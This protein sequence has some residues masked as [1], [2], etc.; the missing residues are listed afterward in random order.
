MVQQ[1]TL[2]KLVSCDKSKVVNWL[3]VHSKWNKEDKAVKFKVDNWFLL[4]IKVWIVVL[5]PKF[6]DVSWLSLQLK[7]SINVFW[8][9]SSTVNWLLLQDKPVREEKSS[10]PVKSWIF[11]LETLKEVTP[12]ILAVSTESLFAIPSPIEVGS[13]IET[14][15]PLASCVSKY[16]SKLSSGT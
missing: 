8:L 7:D 14:V 16:A 1:T 5:A 12:L 15:W 2:A 3:L 4:Q 6:K 11:S 9:K 10:I 13:P